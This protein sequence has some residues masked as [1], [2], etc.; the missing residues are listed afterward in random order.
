MTIQSPLETLY[1]PPKVG[2]ATGL[3]A[4]FVG[5]FR[6]ERPHEAVRWPTDGLCKNSIRRDRTPRRVCGL[7]RRGLGAGLAGTHTATD[8]RR[9][10]VS[11]WAWSQNF[12]P[13]YHFGGR[14]LI[15]INWKT[16]VYSLQ[17]CMIAFYISL[18]SL[19]YQPFFIYDMWFIPAWLTGDFCL[20]RASPSI[21]LG[22]VI[23]QNKGQEKGF[24][25]SYH[26]F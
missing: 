20:L 7:I 9:V 12:G 8:S 18:P 5:I 1:E 22:L 24:K 10:S 14:N 17:K 11:P 23:H 21:L 2:G 3:Q 4:V 25:T 6:P 13:W 15:V 26:L 19:C 16:N